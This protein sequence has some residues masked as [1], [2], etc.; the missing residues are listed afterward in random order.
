MSEHWIDHIDVLIKVDVERDKAEAI[1]AV[2]D[3]V[4]ESMAKT[5][6]V[7]RHFKDADSKSDLKLEAVKADMKADIQQMLVEMHKIMNRILLAMFA[8]F[9]AISSVAIRLWLY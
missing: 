4:T 3:K 7:E 9:L 6:D 5:D 8:L 1:V 2:I